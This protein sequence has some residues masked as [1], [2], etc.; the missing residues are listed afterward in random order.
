MSE[1]NKTVQETGQEV[2]LD[3]KEKTYTAQEYGALVAENKKYRARAQSVEAKLDATTKEN[4]QNYLATL[5]KNEKYK[6]LAN[7]YKSKL[8]KVEPYQE[9]YLQ[10]KNVVREDYLNKL[11]DSIRKNYESPDIPMHTLQNIVNDFNQKETPK[12]NNAKAGRFA[13]YETEEDLAINNHKKYKETKK[14]NLMNF[15][16]PSVD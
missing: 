11:P 12:V 7:T 16:K 6:D 13:G 9:K 3:S 1:E 10:L 14:Q 4:E 2:A 5:E 15:F 8:E